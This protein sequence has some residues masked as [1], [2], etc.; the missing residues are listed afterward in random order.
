MFLLL[1]QDGVLVYYINGHEINMHTI[2]KA[3]PIVFGAI[4]IINATSG[5]TTPRINT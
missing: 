2:S 5:S 1:S 4:H 3:K